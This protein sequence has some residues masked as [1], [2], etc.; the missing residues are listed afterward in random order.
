MQ[1]DNFLLNLAQHAN[2]EIIEKL[3]KMHITFIDKKSY[4]T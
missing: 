1:L 4:I 3:E 2:D